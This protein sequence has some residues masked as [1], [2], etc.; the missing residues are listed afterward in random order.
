MGLPIP[1]TERLKTGVHTLTRRARRVRLGV[2]DYM[3]DRNCIA[4]RAAA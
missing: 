2:H 3:M 4:P 1:Y